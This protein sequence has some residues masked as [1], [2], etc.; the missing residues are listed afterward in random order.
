MLFTEYNRTHHERRL[1]H[2]QKGDVRRR[3]DGK[4]RYD[5]RNGYDK[6]SDRSGDRGFDRRQD[7]GRKNFKDLVRIPTCFSC[8]E[9]GQYPKNRQKQTKSDQVRVVVTPTPKQPKLVKGRVGSNMCNMLLD[10]CANVMVVAARL[11]ELEQYLPETIQMTG[12][13]KWY[14]RVSP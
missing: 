1:K 3:D 12:V 10:S 2:W 8:Q 11:V 13:A 7:Q 6:H 4:W 9:K 5:T 14:T